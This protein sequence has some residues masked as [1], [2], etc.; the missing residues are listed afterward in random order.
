MKNIVY[1]EKV[2]EVEPYGIEQIPADERH[3]HPRQMFSIWFAINLNVVTWFTGFLGIEFGLSIGYAIIAIII[4]NVIGAAYLAAGSCIG[5]ELGQPLIPA[6]R[7]FFGRFGVFGLSLLNLINNIGWLAVNLLLAVMA[8][9]TI[10]P[11]GFHVSVIILTAVTLL[12]AI[13]GYNFIHKFAHYMSIIVGI[14][15]IGITAISF[16]NLPSILS[17]SSHAAGSFSWSMFILC[18]AVT[19]AYQISYCPI[20]TDYSRYMPSATPKRKLW[21]ASFAGAFSVCLWLEILGAATATLGM[22]SDPMIFLAQLMGPFTIP[23]VI[24]VILSI[25]PVNA[26]TM[27]SGGLAAIAM[28][29]P[30]KR[31]ASALLTAGVAALLISFGS[32]N[33]SHTYSNFLLLLS[34]WI[35]PWLIIVLCD[36]FYSKKHPQFS[37]NNKSWVGIAAFLGGILVSVPFMSSALYT[38]PI[39]ANYLKGTDISY[40]V[41]LLVSMLI[42][43]F[44]IKLLN[45]SQGI[46][47]AAEM[48]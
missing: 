12:V 37:G 13:Y 23:A 29:I 40:F 38:G 42:Y 30:L 8:F 16:K 43:L 4:G 32:S 20:S 17:H 1:Q 5:A 46:S 48:E 15:F 33:L 18:I 6:S 24:T 35:T 10:I 22:N 39:A 34:Y 44:V 26:M 19:F 3:G 14:L 27:Y 28:G 31:W 11:V 36:F 9:R 45:A 47:T 7:K 2:L 21:K 25:L 41:S